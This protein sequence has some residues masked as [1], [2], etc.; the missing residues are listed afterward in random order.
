M[1]GQ[2]FRE[3]I[4]GELWRLAPVACLSAK[5]V[6]FLLSE[7]EHGVAM[8][9]PPEE[10]ARVEL[11][12]PELVAELAVAAVATYLHRCGMQLAS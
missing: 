3:R 8:A 6:A 9:F 1:N 5:D 12:R 4:L 2:T 11:L 7:V 10:R